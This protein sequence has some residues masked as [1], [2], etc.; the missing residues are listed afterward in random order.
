LIHI[1]KFSASGRLTTDQ[2]KSGL[3]DYSIKYFLPELKDELNGYV[4]QGVIDSFV[5]SVSRLKK[6]EFAYPEF[7]AEMRHEGVEEAVAR[8]LLE[9]LF[10]CSGI[11][12][13]SNSASG[14]KYFTFKFRNRNSVLNTNDRLL[15][16]R[17]VWKA[18]NLP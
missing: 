18:L 16:H 4:S 12:N 7:L 3:R 11:G 17:G 15:L 9:A 5:R 6:R 8:P 13:I 2:V 14:Q 1:Q 10:E